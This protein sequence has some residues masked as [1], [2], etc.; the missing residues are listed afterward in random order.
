TYSN[1]WPLIALSAYGEKAAANLA[2]NQIEVAFAGE[3]HRVELPAKPGSEALSFDFE[4]SDPDRAL[5][6]ETSGNAPVYASLQI[7]TRPALM[8][9]EA[10][11]N[12]FAITR[13]Y[14]K[15]ESDGSIVPLG[16]LRIGD[17]VL[18]TLDLNIP[19]ERETYL[20][21]DDPL[22]AIFE[23]VNPTFKT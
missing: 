3:T 6:L 1:A 23:A 13:N 4:G 11:N 9:L 16:E 17:L 8:P 7:A 20:A 2:G 14:R 10:E 19:N 12:G 15:V 5:S 18:V 21:I 22:P